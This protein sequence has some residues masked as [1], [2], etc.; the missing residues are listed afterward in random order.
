MVKQKFLHMIFSLKSIPSSG[1]FA[2]APLLKREKYL[3]SS[4]NICV[5]IESAFVFVILEQGFMFYPAV[6]N[7]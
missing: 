1:I 6:F 2:F 7:I 4:F 5:N 3:H